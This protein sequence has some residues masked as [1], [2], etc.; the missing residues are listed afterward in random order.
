MQGLDAYWTER[1]LFQ[2]LSDDNRPRQSMI[3]QDR[4]ATGILMRLE[5]GAG[6]CPFFHSFHL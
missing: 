2:N 5:E 6:V 4:I 1:T 3:V